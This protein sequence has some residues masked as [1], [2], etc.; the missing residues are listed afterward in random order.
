MRLG[1]KE[2]LEQVM[3]ETKTLIT[4]VG[5]ND[6][7]TRSDASLQLLGTGLEIEGP[8]A[9]VRDAKVRSLVMLDMTV[10]HHDV[11]EL[12]ILIFKL[13]QAGL[14]CAS[15]RVDSNILPLILGIQR[16]SLR[17]LVQI[18]GT[19]IYISSAKKRLPNEPTQ[20]Q[21]TMY[22]TGKK[23]NVISIL[24]KIEASITQ[25]VS[26][27]HKLADFRLIG[28]LIAIVLKTS[29]SGLPALKA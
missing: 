10:L 12:S 29:P 6:E 5:R 16:K 1:I 11:F 18:S 3:K 27:V 8:E 7:L 25:K 28:A 19:N 4:C 20:N 26:F 23:R 17:N 13:L 22:I 14:H 2:K 21:V 24:P 15:L 9:N